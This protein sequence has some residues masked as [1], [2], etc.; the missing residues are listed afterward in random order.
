MSL[1]AKMETRDINRFPT[2][3]DLEET[4]R[5]KERER[6]REKERGRGRERALKRKD[7]AQEANNQGDGFAVTNGLPGPGDTRNLSTYCQ[8]SGS[9]RND[10]G[11]KL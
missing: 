10:T 11:M 6:E 2:F 3:F 5:K 1:T 7:M 8:R 4:D 9:S